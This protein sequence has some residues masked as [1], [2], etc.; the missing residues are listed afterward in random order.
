MVRKKWV[1][2]F[3]VL[4]SR[5]KLQIPINLC[6][7]VHAL[8]KKNL[9]QSWRQNSEQ[10]QILLSKTSSSTRQT[11][12]RRACCSSNGLTEIAKVKLRNQSENVK[13][14]YCICICSRD[15]RILLLGY[16][17]DM[18]IRRA[19]KGGGAFRAFAPPEILK[20][21]HSNFNICR[22]FQITK[23]QFYIL[24]IFEKSYW[25]FSLSYW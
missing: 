14:C 23:M 19:T 17:R 15:M 5:K 12:T 10:R 18:H 13:K 25:N 8:C 20:T 22:N 1:T 3:T 6:D 24:I 21:L 9:G 7:N 16:S 11:E 2:F 4:F